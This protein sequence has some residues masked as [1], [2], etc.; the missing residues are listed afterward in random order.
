MSGTEKFMFDTIFDELEPIMPEIAEEELHSADGED[1]LE[2]VPVEEI[3]P[4]FSEEEVNAA[5]QEGFANGKEQGI[6]E[7]L[8]GIEKTTGDTL[9]LISN[10]LAKLF[11]DQNQAN[12]EI[13]EDATALSLAIFR[14]FFPSLNQQSALDEVTSTVVKILN[15]L[16]DEPRILIKANT[17]ISEDLAERLTRHFEEKGF[18]GNLSVIADDD[19]TMGDCKLEWSNGSAERNLSALMGEI[20]DIIAQNSTSPMESLSAIEEPDLNSPGESAADELDIVDNEEILAENS[21]EIAGSNA[22]FEQNIKDAELESD[23]ISDD[24]LIKDGL[25]DNTEEVEAI[26]SNDENSEPNT[27]EDGDTL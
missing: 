13:S 2:E 6:S 7:T 9:N 4:T 24:E 23:E 26:E 11:A 25:E 27:D 10:N 19:V 21:Q 15:R 14:K 1:L 3:I 20:D 18:N 17:A 8:A 22:I 16:I 5:R 12:Q